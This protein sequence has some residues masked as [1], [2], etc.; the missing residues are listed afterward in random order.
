MD[1]NVKAHLFEPFFTTKEKGKG[2][3]LGLSTVYGVV[4]QGGGH[5]WVY[6]EMGKGTSFEIHFPSQGGGAAP[7]GLD[8]A[9]VL[10]Q[11]GTET[12]LLV[13]DEPQL[14]AVTALM[15]KQLGYRVIE[16]QNAG[17][18]VAFVESGEGAAI[19]LLLSDVV[20]PEMSGRVLADR[21]EQIRPGI[22]V[23]F[24][25]GYTDDAVLD[26]GVTSA[27][28]CFLQKPFSLS[29]LDLKIREALA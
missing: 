14:L 3:G 13:E 20:M 4:K 23:L 17:D 18:A 5:A 6:S 2:T 25:S 16:K 11:G 21:I 29:D 19:D 7:V 12:I 8:A 28:I 9:P 15:L 26:H 1:E 24:V 10:P 22:K 27:E